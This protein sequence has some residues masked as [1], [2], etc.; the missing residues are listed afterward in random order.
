VVQK[1]RSAAQAQAAR[2]QREA[3]RRRLKVIIPVVAGVVVIAVVVTVILLQPDPPPSK[4]LRSAVLTGAPPI[5]ITGGSGTYSVVYRLESYD[6]SGKKSVSTED[7]SVRRPFDGRVLVREGNPPSDTVQLDLRSTFALDG[8]YSTASAVHVGQAKPGVPL[9]DLRLD[10]AIDDLVAQ[11][12]FVAR[13]QRTVLNRPCQVYRTGQ[14]LETLQVSAPTATDYADVCVDADGMELEEVGIERGK[15]SVYVVALE[16]T[17]QAQLTDDTFKI[18][19]T[20]VPLEQGGTTTTEVDGTK[21][22]VAGFAQ[23]ATTP[24]GFTH[25]PRY[26][27]TVPQQPS[28]TGAPPPD[29][30][31]TYVDSY[32]N[33]NQIVIVEQGASIGA[34]TPTDAPS[35][36][37]DLGPLGKG[38][39]LPGVEGNTLLLNPNADWFLRITG[40]MT[41]SALQQFAAGLKLSS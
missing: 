2:L 11:K 16:V 9:G 39:F 6:S 7:V 15:L 34:P 3:R 22:P 32:V 14:A 17:P 28:T 29:P 23:F 4:A 1:R 12:V 37:V 26:L 25:K 24:S 31:V 41:S 13:E 40:T 36:D 19:G 35:L 18:D 8:D 30:V 27:V 20:P 33:G 10:T 38:K 21:A 5:T